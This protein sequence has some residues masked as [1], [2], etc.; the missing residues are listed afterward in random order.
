M[1]RSF[2]TF[3]VTFLVL[4]PRSARTGIVALGA[5]QAV[6]IAVVAHSFTVPEAWRY[7]TGPSSRALESVF[8][9]IRAKVAKYVPP[10]QMR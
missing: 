10:K 8:E 5:L 6:R 3:E 1:E 4:A 7:A 2:V 9:E